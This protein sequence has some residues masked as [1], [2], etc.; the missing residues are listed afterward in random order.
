MNKYY[1]ISKIL[2]LVFWLYLLK[3]IFENNHEQNNDLTFYRPALEISSFHHMAG[4]FSS[5]GGVLVLYQPDI[6]LGC[7]AKS[8]SKI[9]K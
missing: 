8:L 9:A 3:T 2:K 5:V 4:F 6:K 7:K 1:S